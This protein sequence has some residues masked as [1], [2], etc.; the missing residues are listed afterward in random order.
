MAPTYRISLCDFAEKI[1]KTLVKSYKYSLYPESKIN[2]FQI[3]HLSMVIHYPNGLKNDTSIENDSELWRHS[4]NGMHSCIDM[5]IRKYISSM[6]SLRFDYI[7]SD[8]FAEISAM[9]M[10]LVSESLIKS[11]LE[12]QLKLFFCFSF[13]ITNTTIKI[14]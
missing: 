12:I 6:A 5:E 8:D 13:F 11:F 2:L 9:L 14:L 1:V 4:L 10:M 3:F 7:L